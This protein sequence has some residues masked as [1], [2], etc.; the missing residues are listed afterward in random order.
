[1]LYAVDDFGNPYEKPRTI[2]PEDESDYLRAIWGNRYDGTDRAS[3]KQIPWIPYE[4]IFYFNAAKKTGIQIVDTQGV[5]KVT[6]RCY[7]YFV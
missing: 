3:Q 4:A 5:K 2:P 6:R 1:M 7:C